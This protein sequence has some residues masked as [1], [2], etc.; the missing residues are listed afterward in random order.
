VV[1]SGARLAGADF[2]NA[3]LP[4]ANFIGADLTDARTRGTYL[5]GVKGW[6]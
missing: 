6:P 5:L 3:Y 4:Y 2:T 1:F